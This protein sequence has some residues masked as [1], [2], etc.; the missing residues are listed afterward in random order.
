MGKA[1]ISFPE[2]MLEQV[3]SLAEERSTTRSGFVQEAVAHYVTELA[4]DRERAERCGRI[5]EAA[6]RMADLGQLIPQGPEGTVLIRHMRD[7]VPGWL[8]HAERDDE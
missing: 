5:E 6:R 7:G 3:D 1:N 8:D 2:G 4:R